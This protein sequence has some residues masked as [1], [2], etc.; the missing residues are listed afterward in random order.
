MI[1]LLDFHPPIIA[2]RGAGSDAPEN[3]LAAIRSAHEQGSTWIELD[4]K[5][6]YDGIPILMHDDTLER[7]T[8]GAGL[9]AQA[10]WEDLKKLDAGAKF[11]SQ[12]KGEGIPSLEEAVK[13]ILDLDMS[14]VAELKPCPGRAKAT[15]MVAM[16]ELAKAWPERDLLPVIAS[17]DMDSLEMAA[18]LEPHWPRCLLFREWDDQWRQKVSQAGACAISVS[19]DQLTRDRVDE[20]IRLRIPLLAY[21]VNDPE[22]AKELLA[23]GA[24]AVYVDSPRSILAEL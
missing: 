5:I 18:Q 9:V 20:V 14:F 2:H 24:S 12:F 7:T 11:D 6:T 21:T 19:S 22:R 10:T 3:T 23:W 16:I 15:T 13:L 1:P 17:F 4:I 8:S